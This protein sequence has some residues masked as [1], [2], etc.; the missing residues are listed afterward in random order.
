[1][2]RR[3][4]W[5][6]YLTD[7][8]DWD[9]LLDVYK[10]GNIAS[11]GSRIFQIVAKINADIAPGA[12]LNNTATV[13]AAYVEERHVI[14]IAGA[15][16]SGG[17]DRAHGRDDVADGAPLRPARGAGDDDLAQRPRG[18]RERDVD[19]VG[20]QAS[21]HGRAHREHRHRVV[22]LHDDAHAVGQR[23]ELRFGVRALGEFF[24]KTGGD[25][26]AFYNYSLKTIGQRLIPRYIHSRPRR[27]GGCVA[28]L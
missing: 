27:N 24:G 6:S 18:G 19:N 14:D 17:C 28:D 4:T 16:D 5:E 13:S 20:Q 26:F 22:L 7:A 3:T 9:V 25:P 21:E 2:W 8:P 23:D 15:L 10:I 12:S 11:G 1:M